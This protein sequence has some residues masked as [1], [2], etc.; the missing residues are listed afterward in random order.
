MRNIVPPLGAGSSLRRTEKQSSRFA[1]LAKPEC[2]VDH[3]RAS[4][5]GF[6]FHRTGFFAR[7]NRASKAGALLL[8]ST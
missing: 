6:D 1:R 7:R 3:Q 2:R 5:N 8:Y 4:G